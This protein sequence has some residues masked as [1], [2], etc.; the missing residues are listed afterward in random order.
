MESYPLGIAII[1][2]DNA[3]SLMLAKNKGLPLIFAIASNK[4][5]PY[6]AEY[7]LI[8]VRNFK[9]FREKNIWEN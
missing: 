6:L 7:Q 5:Y 1:R 9:S 2:R 3:N 8:K 4:K